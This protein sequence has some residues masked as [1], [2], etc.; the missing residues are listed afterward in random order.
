MLAAFS[1]HFFVVYV[2][3]KG[4]RNGK[5]AQHVWGRL[6]VWIREEALGRRLEGEKVEKEGQ[7]RSHYWAGAYTWDSWPGFAIWEG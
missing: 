1:M 4:I 5:G 3:V 7:A 2:W 6:M